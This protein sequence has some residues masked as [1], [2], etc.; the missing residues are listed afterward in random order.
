MSPGHNGCKLRQG[1]LIGW[2]GRCEEVSARPAVPVELLQVR[3]LERPALL[4]DVDAVC[5]C[6]PD[7]WRRTGRSL[8]RL[9]G[10]LGSRLLSLLLPLVLVEVKNELRAAVEPL[11]AQIRRGRLKLRE[12]PGNEWDGGMH[13]R[14]HTH[15][16]GE[17]ALTAARR[18]GDASGRPSS[19][20]P[21]ATREIKKVLSVSCLTPY[22]PSPTS[23][24]ASLCAQSGLVRFQMSSFLVSS[25]PACPCLECPRR[26]C[27][28]RQS[29]FGKC[30]A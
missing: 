13:R 6:I 23:G 29:L 10:R 4:A 14:R 18:V 7:P 25:L 26:V 12:A 17:D 30:S 24:I 27:R 28:V 8:G 1:R 22:C 21:W 16:L 19:A 2:G 11:A 3:S 20:S 5:V 9:S 15:E